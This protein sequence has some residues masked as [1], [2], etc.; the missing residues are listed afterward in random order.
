M[1][2]KVKAF[3]A[4]ARTIRPGWRANALAGALIGLIKL[5]GIRK[6]VAL[7]NITLCFPEKS[8][9]ERRTI[10]A[11]SYESMIWTGVEMLGWQQDPT[12]IDRMLV[13]KSGFENLDGVLAK[14]H[15]A[16]VISAHLSNWE[17]AAAWMS[18][19]YPFW[20]IVRESDSPFQR[21]LIE[22]LRERG[23]LRTIDNKSS[24]KKIISLL[25]KN[26]VF[27]ALADQHGGGGTA[28]MLPFFGQTTATAPGPGAFSVLTGAPMLPVT[29][30]RIEPFKFRGKM[31]EPI[32]PPKELPRDEAITFMTKKMNEAY[33]TMIKSC[34]GQW[35]WQH[36]RFR[37]IIDEG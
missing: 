27:G 14:G 3:T 7:R 16:V 4:F 35:L 36:R 26:E 33:E 1:D 6:S 22:T 20:G 15:G 21:E 19:R 32:Y 18:R 24:L 23:G 8:E 17:F 5:L 10:L 2:P 31:G 11:E 29:F 30:T 25:R 13:E 12:L 28:L 9:A 37:E 34:P